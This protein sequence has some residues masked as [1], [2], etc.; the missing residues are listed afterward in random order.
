V[1]KLVQ[2]LQIEIDLHPAPP[3]IPQQ[4]L[5]ITRQVGHHFQRLTHGLAPARKQRPRGIALLDDALHEWRQMIDHVELG[6]ELLPQ[7]FQRDQR[8]EQQGQ[9]GGQQ[10]IVV[11]HQ[12]GD[13]VQQ[14]ADLHVLELQVVVALQQ[15]RHVVGQPILVDHRFAAPVEQHLQ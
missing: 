14:R 1:A 2:P 9:I 8:L 15:L 4:V 11:A 13:V 5:Q 10:Q 12:G 3:N 6:V 7:P